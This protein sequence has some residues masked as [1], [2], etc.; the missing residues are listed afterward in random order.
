[1]L[2]TYSTP[3]MPLGLNWYQN[4]QLPCRG[5]PIHLHAD[6]PAAA[7][8]R[9]IYPEEPVPLWK[10]LTTS[11]VAPLSPGNLDLSGWNGMGK[12]RGIG[13]RVQ[14]STKLPNV[15]TLPAG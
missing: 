15:G 7:S 11:Q 1:M 8:P 4:Q 2:V 13:V 14:G 12:K 5:V 9:W 3:N 10:E 6:P